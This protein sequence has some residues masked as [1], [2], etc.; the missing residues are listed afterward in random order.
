LTTHPESHH[1]YHGE[2]VAYGI[3]TQLVLEQRSHEEIN[4][5]LDFYKQIG[6]PSKLREL[7]IT[8]P[9]SSEQLREIA[10]VSLSPDGTMG[11]MP[12]PV[13]AEMVI[14]AIHKV[15]QL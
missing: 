13:T 14:E 5:L 3:I 8:E 6:L 12:F 15:E 10:R 4:E 7:G 1:A 2:K 11:N 9:L